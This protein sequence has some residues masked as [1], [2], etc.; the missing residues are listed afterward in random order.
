MTPYRSAWT[1]TRAP[2]IVM[3]VRVADCSCHVCKAWVIA[4]T[5]ARLVVTVAL[6]G[7]LWALGWMLTA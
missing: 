1:H 7:V 4:N 3:D 2:W 5:A 6:A